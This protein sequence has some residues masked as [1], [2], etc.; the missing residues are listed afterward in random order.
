[1]L[2]FL[3]GDSFVARVDLRADRKRSALVVPAAH[4]E[5]ALDDGALHALVD[6]LWLLAGWL[7][8]DAVEVGEQGDLAEVL[9][10][11][12]REGA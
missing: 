5:P 6:E 9:R 10:E 3:Y 7:G 11:V 2:P 12:A 8:L 4:S 1:V